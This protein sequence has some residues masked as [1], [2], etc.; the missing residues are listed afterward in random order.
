MFEK[1]ILP[2]CQNAQTGN[3]PGRATKKSSKLHLPW[4]KTQRWDGD[5]VH[6]VEQSKRFNATQAIKRHLNSS[7]LDPADPLCAYKEGDCA[8]VID[9]KDF[10]LMCNGIWSQHGFDRYT[11]PS[12]R[13][14]GTTMLLRSGV[15]PGVVKKMGRWESDAFILYWRDLESIFSHHAAN[16]KAEER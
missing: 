13:I 11:G 16:L 6:L 15:E 10:M 14:G 12:F 4:T 3:W 8:V 7:Q 5:V 1:W 2:G 9:K